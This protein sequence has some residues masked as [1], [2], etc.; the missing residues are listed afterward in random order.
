MSDGFR[1]ALLTAL[2]VSILVIGI[3]L[4]SYMLLRFAANLDTKCRFQAVKRF[5][6]ENPQSADESKHG[7]MR[8]VHWAVLTTCGLPRLSIRKI[9]A[10]W[11]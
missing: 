11:Q 4:F 10:K 2:G 6:A 9:L 8:R 3:R 1:Y 5:M 7:Y